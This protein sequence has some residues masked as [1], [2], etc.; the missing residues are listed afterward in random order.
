MMKDFVHHFFNQKN[1]LKVQKYRETPYE[2][3]KRTKYLY[4]SQK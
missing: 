3:V 2:K 1:N 4:I